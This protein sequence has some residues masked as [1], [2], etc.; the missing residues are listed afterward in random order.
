MSYVGLGKF[1]HVVQKSYI[2]LTYSQDILKTIPLTFLRQFSTTS[3]RCL[4]LFLPIFEVHFG[5]DFQTSPPH[6]E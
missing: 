5:H 1:A 4:N 2:F 3:Y 6:A